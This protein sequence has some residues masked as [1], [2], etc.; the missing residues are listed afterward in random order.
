MKYIALLFI[1]LFL[2]TFFFGGLVLLQE[3]KCAT[4]S[5]QERV[6]MRCQKALYDYRGK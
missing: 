1:T 2:I 5:P 6:E 4:A 3:P